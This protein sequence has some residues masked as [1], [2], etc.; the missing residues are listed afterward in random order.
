L[1]IGARTILINASLTNSFIYHMSM[2]LLH[3]TM[4]KRLDKGRRFFWHSNGL[5]R[6]FH[7]VKWE[8]VCRP[9]K[10]GGLGIKDMRKLNLSLLCKWWWI[11]ETWEGLWQ[12]LVR[13]KYIKQKP[14]CLVPNRHNV[15]PVWSD[16]LKVRHIYVK[17]KTFRVNNGQLVSF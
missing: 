1:S 16:L 4:I 13:V 2:Y 7:L 17:G 14:L 8:K 6:K 9:K 15:S 12:D 3:E 5:K 10:K 11:L